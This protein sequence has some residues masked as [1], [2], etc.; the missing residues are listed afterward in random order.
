MIVY[1]QHYRILSTSIE[2]LS[3]A[4]R[5]RYRREE[6][7]LA[8]LRHGAASFA[9]RRLYTAGAR[10]RFDADILQQCFRYGVIPAARERRHISTHAG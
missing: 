1:S 7:I 4:A 3:R 8:S 10:F 9:R 5:E 6:C 2:E